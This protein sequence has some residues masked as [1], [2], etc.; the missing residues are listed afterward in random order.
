MVRMFIEIK[1]C[2][3]LQFQIGHDHK[4]GAANLKVLPDIRVQ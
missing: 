2:L 4:G 3:W 1:H